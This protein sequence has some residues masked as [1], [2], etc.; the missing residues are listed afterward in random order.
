MRVAPHPGCLVPLS[1]PPSRA[2]YRR[3]QACMRRSGVPAWS[4]GGPR[5]RRPASLISGR[6]LARLARLEWDAWE[7]GATHHPQAAAAV[8]TCCAG[9]LAPKAVCSIL[10]L[11]LPRPAQ[12]C[13][14]LQDKRRR[15]KG[16][17]CQ[18]QVG[19]RTAGSGHSMRQGNRM[20]RAQPWPARRWRQRPR[21]P[22][23]PSCFSKTTQAG[24]AAPTWASD[25]C[26]SSCSAWR[27]LVCSRSRITTSNGP[28]ACREGARWQRV[29]VR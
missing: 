29:A 4:A 14:A 12:E 3:L 22:R 6:T 9:A 13:H 1:Q 20:R 5:C 10:R 19:R 11:V 8:R 18:Q 21:R 23:L 16:C 17:T 27:R 2:G 7:A 26:A 24:A 25:G 15:R 28:G